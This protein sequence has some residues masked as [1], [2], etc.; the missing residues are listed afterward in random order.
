MSDTYSLEPD[1]SIDTTGFLCPIPVLKTSEQLKQLNAGDVLEVISDDPGIKKDLPA[2][3]EAN[4][5]TLLDLREQEGD[6][7]GYVR[8]DTEIP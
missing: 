8:K 6:F 5:Q 2:W 3:C 4:N 1:H 7:R